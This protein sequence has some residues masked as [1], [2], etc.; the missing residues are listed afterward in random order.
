MEGCMVE[1]EEGCYVPC[2]DTTIGNVLCDKCQAKHNALSTKGET[3][4]GKE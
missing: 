4:G 2:T 3:Q 1:V